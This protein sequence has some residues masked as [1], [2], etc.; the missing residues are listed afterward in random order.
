MP[1]FRP[2]IGSFMLLGASIPC[3][4]Y[5]L[6]VFG[7]RCTCPMLFRCCVRRNDQMRCCIGYV[8]EA[9]GALLNDSERVLLHAML[10]SPEQA[11][12]HSKLKA[13]KDTKSNAGGASLNDSVRLPKSI[14]FRSAGMGRL[15]LS[16]G[17]VA[18]GLVLGGPFAGLVAFIA[19]Q[20][21]MEAY[22]RIVAW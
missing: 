10:Q 17:I 11:Y 12:E 3:Q 20:A 13:G 7:T 18:L 2:S 22:T 15:L 5:F 19:N 16:P 14:A 6:W 8:S 21:C 1:D 9:E 4:I